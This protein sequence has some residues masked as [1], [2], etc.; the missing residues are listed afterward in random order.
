MGE[1]VTVFDFSEILRRTENRVRDDLLGAGPKTVD[2]LRSIAARLRQKYEREILKKEEWGHRRKKKSD[3][4]HDLKQNV[5]KISGNIKYMTGSVVG[6][7]TNIMNKMNSHYVHNPP[8]T[9]TKL[10]KKK[11]TEEIDFALPPNNKNT[12]STKE[13]ENNPSNS[14][15]SQAKMTKQSGI[16]SDVVKKNSDNNSVQNKKSENNAVYSTEDEIDLLQSD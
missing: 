10:E 2:E 5:A 14:S 16:D 8:S 9:T 7:A 3:P 6:G 13:T 4:Q 11:N 12:A 15:S 1:Q